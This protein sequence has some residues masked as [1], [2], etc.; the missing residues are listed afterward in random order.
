MNVRYV[1]VYC[2]VIRKYQTR[3]LKTKNGRIEDAKFRMK[4]CGKYETLVSSRSQGLHWS[5]GE[6]FSGFLSVQC[7]TSS[8]FLKEMRSCSL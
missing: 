8:R 3:C 1:R 2:I 6:W 5:S 7:T 4:L